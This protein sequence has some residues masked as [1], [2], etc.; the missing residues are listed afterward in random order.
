M[1]A[2]ETPLRTWIMILATTFVGEVVVIIFVGEE[3]VV[4][5]ANGLFELSMFLSVAAAALLRDHDLGSLPGTAI[6]IF[7]IPPF[8]QPSMLTL[9]IIRP[10]VLANFYL[11]SNKYSCRQIKQTWY[12]YSQFNKQCRALNSAECWRWT[13]KAMK[14]GGL[15]SRLYNSP[16]DKRCIQH[17]SETS[18]QTS[19]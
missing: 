6:R 9:L 13:L 15:A 12:Y 10:P 2:K 7:F 11:L 19:C 8:L 18:I 14:H 3:V 16:I 4:I 1:I 17:E 5:I